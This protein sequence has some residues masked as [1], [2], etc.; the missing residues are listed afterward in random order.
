MLH[1]LVILKANPTIKLD[2]KRLNSSLSLKTV[3]TRSL[4]P[5]LVRKMISTIIPIT[6]DVLEGGGPSWAC[7]QSDP[8]YFAQFVNFISALRSVDLPPAIHPVHNQHG[9]TQGLNTN[10]ASPN[11]GPISSAFLFPPEYPSSCSLSLHPHASHLPTI[12]TPPPP[13]I[14]TPTNH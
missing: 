11:N 6:I 13:Q 14:N 8:T 2:S 3:P 5:C 4:C 12:A 10:L 7:D 9:N 1:L